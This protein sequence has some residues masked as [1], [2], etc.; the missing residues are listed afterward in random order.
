MVLLLLLLQS[1]YRDLLLPVHPQTCC[2]KHVRNTAAAHITNPQQSRRQKWT[3]Q[4]TICMSLSVRIQAGCISRHIH[5]HE[6]NENKIEIKQ[7]PLQTSKFIAKTYMYCCCSKEP[8][9]PHVLLFVCA[10]S[11]QLMKIS[12]LKINERDIEVMQL[13]IVNAG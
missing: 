8:C 7:N 12:P 9:Y 11:A 5:T 6:K 4:A 1:K 13:N 2:C 10:C 3:I